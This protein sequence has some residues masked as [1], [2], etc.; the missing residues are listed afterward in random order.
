[1]GQAL[2]YPLT[3]KHC[4]QRGNAAFRVGVCAMQGYRTHME[5]AH[6][7]VLNLAKSGKHQNTAF[8]GVYDGHA[9]DRAS[10]FLSE[11]LPQKIAELTD[12]TS[13]KELTE[14]VLAV[15]AEFLERSTSLHELV[16]RKT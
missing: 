7:V 1:M 6:S 8:F 4:Q 16:L 14:A 13:S 5:D 10:L 3:S 15:D 9:G 11:R 12:P 2:A